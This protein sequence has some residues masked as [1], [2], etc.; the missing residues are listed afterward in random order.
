MAQRATLMT[1]T[2]PTAEDHLFKHPREVAV[3]GDNNVIVADAVNHRIR[4][5]SHR[6]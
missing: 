5:T 6:M 3:D 1:E 2:G 4:K